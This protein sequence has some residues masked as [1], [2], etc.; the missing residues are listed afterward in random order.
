MPKDPQLL[1]HQQWLG[2]L[3]PVGLVVSPP[4]LVQ[5][6]AFVNS[7]VAAE[8]AQ[9]LEHV[10]EVN[11]GGDEPIPAIT[12]LK[13]LLTDPHLFAW[14][15]T[16]LV[17]D[18]AKV[19]D[20]EVVLID[21]H[22]TLRPSFAVP[23]PEGG[24]LLLV[25][26]LPLATD[27]DEIAADAKQWQA[28]PQDRFVRLLR[29]AKVPIGLLSNGVAVRLVYAPGGHEAPGH[30][31][32]PVAALSEVAG[33]PA[34]AALLMLL[35][36]ERL[37]TLPDKQRL[38]ALLE[39]SRKYQNTVSTELAEQVLA[40]LFELLRGFQAA[41]GQ[42]KGDLLRDVLAHEPDQ[43][44][45]GLVTVLMRSVFL[46]YAEQKGLMSDADVYVRYYSVSGL[47]ERL[48]EDAGRYPDTMDQRYGAWAH[49]L[50]VFRLTFDGGR[51]TTPNRR[52]GRPEGFELKARHGYLFDADRYPFLEGRARGSQRRKGERI[53]PPLVSDGVVYR[54]LH[55]LL[56][57]DGDRIS[58]G[59]LNV[60]HIGSVYESI[61]GYRLEKAGGRSIALR[62]KK[63]GGA[64]VT[65]NLEA[66]LA[67][68]AGDR[69][70]WL[71]ENA[72]QKVDGKALTALK[73]ADTVEGLVAALEKRIARAL[74]P[75]IVPPGG[76]ILQPSEER[77]RS[78]SH[79]TPPTLTGPVV[80]KALEPV[81]AQLG[82]NPTPEQILALKVC[83][84][85]M[86]SG[87]F[88]VEVCRQLAEALLRAW[89]AHG[90][91]PKVPEDETPELLAQRTVAQRCLYGVDKN[92]MAVDL[93][94]L[95]LWLATL[96]KDHPF[97]FLDHNLKDGDSL[98]GL[99]LRQVRTCHWK[100]AEKEQM[101][102]G[103]SELVR[104]V[105]E[106]LHYRHL[107]LDSDESTPHEIKEQNLRVA[108]EQLNTVRFAG[109]L[110]VAAFFSAEKDKKRHEQREA[111]KSAL[112][113]YFEHPEK[114]NL[115]PNKE[116]RALR[117]GAHPVEP[118]HWEIEFPEVF[119]GTEGS[120]ARGFDCIVGNPPFAGKNTIGEGNRDGYLDWL[121]TIHDESH[122]NADLVAH[123]FRRAFGL[124]RPGGTF[125]LIATNT[126]AQGDTRSSGLRWLCTNGGTI[127]AARR[128]YKWP[129]LAAV[130]VSVVHV[131]KGAT[132]DLLHPKQARCEL[133]GK[134]VDRITAYL[135]HAGGHDDPLQLK[136]NEGKSF[137]GSYVLG[138]G[139]TFDDT[140][141]DGVANP[142]SL[143]HELIDKDARNAERIFP[144][145][146]GEEV[147]D[148]PT[149]AFHRY[150]I[151]FGDMTEE[152]AREWPDLMKIVEEK[153]KPQRSKDNRE[154]RKKYWWRFAE[155]TPALF[156]AL[157]GSNEVIVISRVGQHGVF[158]F[159][160][161]TSVFA[162]SLV[163]V[164]SA[165]C[166]TF[167]A[168]QARVHDIWTRF[169]AS[170][171]EERLR[172][173][174][175][176]CFETFPFPK[177]FETNETLEA[178]GKAYYEF[179]ANLM[180]RNNEGLT[181]TYNHFHDPN[182]T[183]ADIITLRALH[184]AMDR[185]VLDAYGGDLAK[186]TVPPCEFLL[187]YEDEEDEDEPAGGRQRKKPWRYRWP[188]AFRDEVL[189]LLLDLNKK[190]A[191]EE[192][193]T[194]I[195]TAKPK[196]ATP[197]KK[198]AKSD[199]DGTLF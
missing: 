33:R 156:A 65:V 80:R 103:Q 192:K 164:V 45:A 101:V 54:V 41:D 172:Y 129:G 160:P 14:K 106:A 174:P 12:D 181:K 126:I 26:E 133:D 127:Y 190:R 71:A 150:V 88:L 162:E 62:P 86:G 4:A 50:A 182:E 104:R 66:L 72:D 138:M 38:P 48:R 193:L 179:R 63:S 11:A 91:M 119:Q 61:M 64:P 87:A 198:P 105:T 180:V 28:S 3:Q 75:N 115:R 24:W 114:V 177:D 131:V 154:V 187:D 173:T 35:G 117:E 20:L 102:L 6:Q 149:H 23:A 8:Q 155:T 123:F 25:Q 183:S 184:A 196:K 152:Q 189:A 76:M 147:N 68:K 19:R 34:L 112:G 89:V 81:L 60:E 166:A 98:V 47:F 93:A 194:A 27:M 113:A 134:P 46:L 31:T 176:D 110:V 9:F 178:V 40:A 83:D 39:Q 57:L 79:Y 74:T 107:I 44:Y 199:A 186:L 132:H 168:L 163:I 157:T 59:T 37:F 161:S 191:E 143:M 124:L 170:S 141:K 108:N 137:I 109:N 29:G 159:L 85:A 1:A 139:F 92:R 153:V 95:S 197:R 96:A 5:A 130:V 100:P 82:A 49:L 144:Y 169:F 58:Y 53:N 36:A 195:P 128:R 10:K 188:D 16:D 165:A 2:Y 142:I 13:G 171:L 140:D 116:E 111:Y 148:S 97:T 32:F 51:H 56:L 70:K 17:A 136:A 151:N 69:A 122:G 158:T 145:I 55:N 121:K 7:N 167:A 135:F 84:P 21:Y 30:I 42:R 185:A 67:Q 78:G 125:G 146:G 90:Q 18:E 94:K 99:T 120:A 52:T 77:R 15:D 175:S 43:V 73:A 118:F 22:E